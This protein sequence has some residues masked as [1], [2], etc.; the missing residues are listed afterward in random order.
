MAEQP[1]YLLPEEVGDLLRVPVA[2][3]R[4]WLREG[5][6][7]GVK[8]GPRQWRIRRV[9]LDAFLKGGGVSSEA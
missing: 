5:T 9:D 4:R 2:T 6:L 7:R 1:E 8:A 3:V